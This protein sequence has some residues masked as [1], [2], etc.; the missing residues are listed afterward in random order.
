MYCL[1]NIIFFLSNSLRTQV[2][3]L[4][5]ELIHLKVPHILRQKDSESLKM[6]QKCRMFREKKARE[7]H[8]L[9][10]RGAD[11]EK[12]PIFCENRG[13]DSLRWCIFCKKR[14][15]DSLQGAQV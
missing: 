11:S 1:T 15:A 3:V 2:V 13:E 10:K 5:G 7:L 8:I 6:P 14:E 4:R 9:W 12:M